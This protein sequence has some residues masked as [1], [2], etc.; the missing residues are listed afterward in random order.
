MRSYPKIPRAWWPKIAEKY[1]PEMS[2]PWQAEKYRQKQ[3]QI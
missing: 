1:A 3:A 2:G